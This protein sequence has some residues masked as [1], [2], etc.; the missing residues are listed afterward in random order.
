[1]P[2]SNHR[3][4]PSRREPDRCQPAD[5]YAPTDHAESQPIVP[6]DTTDPATEVARLQR[7]LRRMLNGRP[8][9]NRLFLRTADIWLRAALAAGRLS[10]G[11]AQSSA[12]R[13]LAI[14]THLREQLYPQDD[15]HS[16]VEDPP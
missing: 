16:A 15:G 7:R 12:E 4:H 3:K 6:P 5:F 13:A 14:F 2:C 1:M 11:A 9:D 8:G 10:P